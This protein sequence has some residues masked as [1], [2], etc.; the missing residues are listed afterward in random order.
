MPRLS[1]GR[2]AEL[3][4]AACRAELAALKPGNVHVHA[5][6]HG[7]EVGQFEVSAEAAAPW[8]AASEAK[9][10]TRVLRAVEASLAAAGCNTNPPSGMAPNVPWRRRRGERISAC[11]N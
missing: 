9:V 2:I 6:G 10:G 5:G 3:F 8:I 4:L 7:M 11:I 1:E